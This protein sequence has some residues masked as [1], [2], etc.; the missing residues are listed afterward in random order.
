LSLSQPA[1]KKKA[2]QA[3]LKASDA[4]LISSSAK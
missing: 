1:Q 3:P 4:H 2:P